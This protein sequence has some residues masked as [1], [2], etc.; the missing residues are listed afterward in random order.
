M[1]SKQSYR[2]LATAIHDKFCRQADQELPCFWDACQQQI[3]HLH[4]QAR[5]DAENLAVLAWRL[6][7]PFHY[8]LA[9]RWWR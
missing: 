5:V 2:Q 1:A 9:R 6:H 4:C 7:H 3:P 8:W